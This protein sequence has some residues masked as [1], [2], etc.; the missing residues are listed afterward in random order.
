MDPTPRVG[1]GGQGDDERVAVAELG[2]PVLA[3][4]EIEPG[5]LAVVARQRRDGD[6]VG[7]LD[8]RAHEVEVRHSEW[9]QH[10]GPG[11]QFRYVQG[12]RHCRR[13]EAVPWRWRRCRRHRRA[14]YPGTR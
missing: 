4:D 6:D 8:R 2:A 7:F 10:H 3:F 12:R 13:V 14:K 11:G 5:D 9:S 1:V